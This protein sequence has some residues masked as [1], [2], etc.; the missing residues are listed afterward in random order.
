MIFVSADAQ[1]SGTGRAL[2]AHM[3][4]QA[5]ETGLHTVRVSPTRL[6]KVL[7]PHGRATY[8]HSRSATA[9]DHVGPP[10]APLRLP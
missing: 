3:I 5:Q 9:H 10:R 1:R 2:V 4:E 6:T 7:R 8:R